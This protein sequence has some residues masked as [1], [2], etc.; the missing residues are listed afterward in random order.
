MQ[1][2]GNEDLAAAGHMLPRSSG[3]RQWNQPS[4][5][6]KVKRGQA[7]YRKKER[8]NRKSLNISVTFSRFAAKAWRY[9]IC[10]DRQVYDIV[11]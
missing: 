4:H 8:E 1:K 10:E 7:N 9:I 2:L 6:Q 11:C 5:S 3:C